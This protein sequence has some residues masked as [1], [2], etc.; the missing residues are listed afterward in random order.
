MQTFYQ[1]LVDMDMDI[2]G[3]FR[4]TQEELRQNPFVSPYDWAGFVLVE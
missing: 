2:P 4:A 1:H 3:A